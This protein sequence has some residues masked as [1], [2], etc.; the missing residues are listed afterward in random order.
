MF[1]KI[2]LLIFSVMSTAGSS[3]GPRDG[4]N[5]LRLSPGDDLQFQKTKDGDLFAEVQV[6]N[7]AAKA[8][9]YKVKTTSPDKFR[10]RPSIAL[11]APGGSCVVEIHVQAK[12]GQARVTREE[13]GREGGRRWVVTQLSSK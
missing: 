3:R 6:A 1:H 10:V 8:V 9:V 2:F 11:L 13:T 4:P 5:L 7:I 12:G